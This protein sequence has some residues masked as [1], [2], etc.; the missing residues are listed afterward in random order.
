MVDEKY[1]ELMQKE[2]D[3]GISY[4]EKARLASYLKGSEEAREL[5]KNLRE[6]HRCLTEAPLV[7]APKSL[8]DNVMRQVV[9]RPRPVINPV[10]SRPGVWESLVARFKLQPAIPFA[11]GVAMG[12]LALVP[13]ISQNPGGT[14]IDTSR[15]IGTLLSSDLDTKV[16][17]RKEISFGLVKGG[18][19]VKA[20]EGWILVDVALKSPDQISLVLD[21]DSDDIAFYGLTNMDRG[22]TF[23]ESSDRE[24]RLTHSGV[25]QYYLAF[26]DNPGRVSEISLRLESGGESYE[27]SILTGHAGR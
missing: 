13:V 2:I 26:A 6:I 3:G 7:D 22:S 25:R 16:I 27:E 9:P 14:T 21:Y 1:I 8:R 23:V 5:Q 18:V 12:V 10:G 24:L 19:E 15:L 11:V 20:F 17:D 4:F